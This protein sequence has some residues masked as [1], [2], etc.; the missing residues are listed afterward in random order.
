MP[1]RRLITALSELLLSVERVVVELDPETYRTVP[2]PFRTGSI[3]VHLRHC[4]DTC[5]ALL[6]GLSAGRIDYCHRQRDPQ[7]EELPS[8]FLAVCAELRDALAALG[9]L[10]PA[11]EL[12]VLP[13]PVVQGERPAA[14]TSNLARELEYLRS[15]TLHHLAMVGVLLRGLG[16]DPGRE[17]GVAP[18]TLAYWKEKERCVPRPG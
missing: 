5:R 13:E 6:E 17:L 8:R 2:E 4:L 3:G 12:V 1:H 16:I 14:L 11:R 18:S 10:D 15:H 9:E 7:V